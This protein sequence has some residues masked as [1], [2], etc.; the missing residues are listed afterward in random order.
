MSKLTKA[1]NNFA[2]GVDRS[3]WW[4]S[5]L[6]FEE[7]EEK[8][9]SYPYKLAKEVYELYLWHNGSDASFETS[10]DDLGHYIFANITPCAGAT[11]LSIEDAINLWHQ[12]N[13]NRNDPI[14][15]VFPLFSDEYGAIVTLGCEE[16]QETSPVYLVDGDWYNVGRLSEPYYP[17]LTNMILAAAEPI[18]WKI[19]ID[20]DCAYREARN[21][22]EEKYGG[23]RR[24]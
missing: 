16:Q 6:T 9:K 15:E 5:Q 23:V 13:S 19:D 21:A 10:E 22:I 3:Y 11:L 2:S 14:S 12:V 17:S 20:D 1:L 24:W 4:R 8:L 7:I 18:R